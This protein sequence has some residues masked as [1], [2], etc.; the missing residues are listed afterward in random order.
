M[1]RRAFAAVGRPAAARLAGAVLLS[2]SAAVLFAGAT[3]AQGPPRAA[4]S[5]ARTPSYPIHAELSPPTFH[6]GERATY[7]GWVV[8]PRDEEVRWIP[9]D[10]GGAFTWGRPVARRIHGH[11][12][13]MMG[14]RMSFDTVKVEIPLQAF[15]LGELS[16][17]GV[18]LWLPYVLPVDRE[19]IRR[20]PMVRARVLPVLP[21]ADSAADLRPLRGPLAAPWWERA[22]WVLIA[23][24][25]LV[26][27]AVI[28]FVIWRRR[29]PAPVAAAPPP[30]RRD[31]TAEALAELAALRRLDLPGRGRFEEHAFL[32]TRIVRRCLEATAGATQP[33]DTTPEV[34]THLRDARL[35]AGRLTR[36][37]GLLRLWDGVKFARAGSSAEEAR[38][39]ETEAEA[40]IRRGTPDA[41]TAKAG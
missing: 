38:R 37:E 4:G 2:A 34:V 33:G 40:L 29:R 16:V 25:A 5:G 6:L 32:L 15:A 12:A 17:P 11:T 24:L 23:S 41:E 3:A 28:A 36:L 7:R 20:L 39:A 35:D 14:Q 19:S 26:I 13:E 9:P 1:I 27:A 31:P 21:L 18:R 8:V 22:P 30:P 10:S